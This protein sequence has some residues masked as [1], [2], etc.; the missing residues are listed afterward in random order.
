MCD[1][2]IMKLNDLSYKN[3]KVNTAYIEHNN[4]LITLSNAFLP[5]FPDREPSLSPYNSVF[6]FSS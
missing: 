6:I 5:S 2:V 1:L 4:I 3:P